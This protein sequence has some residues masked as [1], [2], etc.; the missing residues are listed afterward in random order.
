MPKFTVT[1]RLA[2]EV[3]VEADDA[4]HALDIVL[5]MDD[6]GP[7]FAVADCDYEIADEKGTDVSHEVTC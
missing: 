5:E 2:L 1:K 6:G 7:E 4:Q 3:E